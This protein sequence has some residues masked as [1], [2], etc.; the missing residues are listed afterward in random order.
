MFRRTHARAQALLPPRRW[1]RAVYL[2]TAVC[3]LASFYGVPASG[4]R[5]VPALAPWLF[6]IASAS[7]IVGAVRVDRAS[8]WVSLT[9]TTAALL[10]RV[11]AL[12]Q[13]IIT[14]GFADVVGQNLAR[15]ERL[16][17]LPLGLYSFV[18]LAVV[19]VWSLWLDPRRW[20]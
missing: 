7:C 14:A 11:V 13:G 1:A 10:W 17:F 19:A 16:T 9:A 8:W 15:Q 12:F 6:G 2:F 4:F 20:S 5:A 18:V 3:L